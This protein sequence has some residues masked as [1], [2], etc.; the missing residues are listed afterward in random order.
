LCTWSPIEAIVCFF[1][2]LFSQLGKLAERAIYFAEVFFIF[3]IFLYTTFV[4]F[5][6]ETSEYTLLT[7]TRFA[8]IPQKSAYHAKYFKKS[9]TYLDLLYKSGRRIGRDD[10]PDIRLAQGTLLWRPVKFGRYSQTSPGTTSTRCSTPNCYA[11]R[12]THRQ[13]CIVNVVKTSRHSSLIFVD[14]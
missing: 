11:G 2:H 9:W 14:H 4:T 12:E 6:P 5:G 1:F 13:N 10:Y 7:I 3:F 8:A